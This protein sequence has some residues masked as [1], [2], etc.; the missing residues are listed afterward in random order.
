MSDY[1]VIVIGG[2]SPGEHCAGAL[3]EGG[4]RVAVVERELVGGE[5]SY[6]ACIPSKSLLRPG[7]AV[8][9]AREAAGEARVDVEAAL[10][11]RDFMVSAYS[12]AGQ[13]RWLSEHHIDLLRGSGRLA[14][15]GVVEVDGVR[16]TADH[17]VLANGAEPVIPP[18]PGLRELDGVWTNREATGMKTVPSHLLILG[19]GPVGVEMAQAVRRLGGTATIVER[20]D[21]VLGREPGPLGH[22]LGDALRREGIELALSVGVVSAGRDGPDYTLELH[23][24]RVLRGDRILVAT[25]RRPRVDGIGLE[26]VGVK[27]DPRG[28]PV[29][30]HLRVTDRVW[31]IGDVNGIWP[32]THVGK[33]Q[34]DVVAANILGH[35]REANY[36]AVPRVVYTDPQAAAV[37]LPEDRFS[38]TV[39]L[40]GVAKTATYTHDYA[41]SNG[42]LTLLS[43]GERLTGAYAL[44]PEAG[45]WLQQATLAIRAH[46]PL[47]V[48][49]DT[50]QPFPTFS[51]IFVDALKVLQQDISGARSAT[52]GRPARAG[53][54]PELDGQTVVVIGG[55]AGIGLE[56]ARRAASEG[57][58]VILTG[59]DP[60][61]LRRAAEEVGA[62]TVSAFDVH[63]D[64]ALNAFFDGLPDPVD[65]VMVTAGRPYYAPLAD[66]DLDE[67]RREL[68][69]APLSVLGIGRRAAGKVRPGGTLI[70]MSGTG[71]RR[72]GVGL[73]VISALTAALPALTANLA[74]EIA[75]VRV[76]LI[77]AGFVDTPLS[78]S[79]LGDGLEARRDQLRANLPIGRV[80]GP[81]DV[82]SLAV[83]LMVNTALTGATY[84]IDGGQQLLSM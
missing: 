77:A 23:D 5:C 6:W 47:D 38:A 36:E 63:D 34:G 31:A 50:I 61:R 72:P 49:A 80:V 75:P 21:H 16:H 82:A 69:D 32:L 70:F 43:D 79:L 24:G 55:S 22:A 68:G 74:L 59:R 48:L 4:L 62:A 64:T 27:P 81:A 8:Q 45:E 19:G 60:G 39:K 44:G 20:G 28:V 7:E 35:P 33:Y 58:R 51:E 84:D 13:E 2:G 54:R 57:A 66:L 78:A 76:N 56:T 52:K 3:A 67:A 11:W 10:A 83:H 42:F 73:G 1:D 30:G 15:S 26:T 17:V 41:D 25:G 14:G 65:H 18:I 29:D 46:L 53:R 37:G 12:D 71:A 40:S 9:G